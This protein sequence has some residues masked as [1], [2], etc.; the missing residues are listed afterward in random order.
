MET[1]LDAILQILAI[2]ASV[3][4][5]ILTNRETR[6][7]LR[8]TLEESERWRQDDR[9]YAAEQEASLVH[10][11]VVADEDKRW[12]VLLHN[13]TRS[14]LRRVHLDVMWPDKDDATDLR[15]IP[16]PGKEPWQIIPPGYWLLKHN[17][18]SYP[19]DFPK[20]LSGDDAHAYSPVFYSGS[21][22][23]KAGSPGKGKPYVSAIRFI[24]ACGNRWR[25]TYHPKDDCPS[26]IELLDSRDRSLRKPAGA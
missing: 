22:C 13:G 23:E 5:V 26:D 3:A 1:Y 19:W 21:A 9:Y 7:E 2:A 24:D 18:D 8:T 11:W 17:D 12:F 4:A 10:A 25:R 6:S 14:P 16:A 20:P 15:L